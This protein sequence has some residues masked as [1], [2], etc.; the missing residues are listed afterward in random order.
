[1]HLRTLGAVSSRLSAHLKHQNTGFG[2]KKL[3]QTQLPQGQSV[4]LPRVWGNTPDQGGG[5]EQCRALKVPTFQIHSCLCQCSYSLLFLLITTRRIFPTDEI[6][7]LSWGEPQQVLRSQE[8]I[9]L[10][11]P[12]PGFQHHTRVFVC[13]S[14]TT[15]LTNTAGTYRTWPTLVYL[16]SGGSLHHC[17]WQGRKN[18]SL[19]V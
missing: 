19:T 3:L 1:M 6:I 5:T 17:H 7:H 2:P 4:Q 9:L 13:M 8:G 12:D 11:L 14:A 10:D 15:A 16:A 18:K